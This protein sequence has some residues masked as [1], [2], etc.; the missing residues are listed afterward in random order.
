MSDE[1]PFLNTKQAATYL[2]LKPNT[3][4]K[5]RVYGGGPIYRKHGRYVRYH[6]RD[7][8]DWSDMRIKHST[9]EE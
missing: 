3:L 8:K 1:T 6:E 9:S 2:G 7:V 4:E 5:M